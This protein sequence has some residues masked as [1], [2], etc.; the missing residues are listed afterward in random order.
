MDT[1]DYNVVSSLTL[2][3]YIGDA[4]ASAGT[5]VVDVVRL[6]QYL[7]KEIGLRRPAASLRGR[8]WCFESNFTMW[9]TFL[10]KNYK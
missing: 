8:S 2:Q 1:E 6:G 3:N 7:S 9:Q 10:F 4:M 5:P